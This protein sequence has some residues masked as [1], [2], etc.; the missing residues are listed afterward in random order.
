MLQKPD[1]G[2]TET[3]NPLRRAVRRTIIDYY[4]FIVFLKLRK[5]R[6]QLCLDECAAVVCGHAGRDLRFA[7]QSLV[8][9][10]I[11]CQLHPFFDSL[12]PRGKAPTR[13]RLPC[14]L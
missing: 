6:F 10:T 11:C 12:A 8:A 14:D 3:R 13:E 9:S 4:D 5:D 7:R 2:I 1:P